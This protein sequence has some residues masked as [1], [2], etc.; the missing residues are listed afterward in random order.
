MHFFGTIYCLFD[1]GGWERYQRNLKIIEPYRN[2]PNLLFYFSDCIAVSAGMVY[3]R[4]FLEFV[5][6]F[7]LMLVI[8]PWIKYWIT[9]NVYLGD[10]GT[11]FVTQV[12][13]SMDDMSL[14]EVVSSVKNYISSAKV[15]EHRRRYISSVFFCPHFQY[16]P[17]STRRWFAVG[18]EH[19]TVAAFVNATHFQD[20]MCSEDCLDESIGATHPKCIS[21][22]ADVPIYRVVLWRNNP[23]HIYTGGE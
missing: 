4:G 5:S 20:T 18:L 15:S 12:G 22:S 19:S 3:R 13:E 6:S 23:Y 1:D 8:N 10:I 11:R 14:D 16:P 21:P 9:A 17:N 7:A 2:G